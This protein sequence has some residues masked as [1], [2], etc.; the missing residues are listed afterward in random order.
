MVVE[1]TGVF[2]HSDKAS[3]HIDAGAKKVVISAPAKGDLKTVV[4]GKELIR[5]GGVSV[6]AP[7][8]L[9]DCQRAAF[10]T[11]ASAHRAGAKISKLLDHGYKVFLT[12]ADLTIEMSKTLAELYSRTGLRQISFDGLEGNRSTGLGTYGESLMPYTWY[13]ALAPELKDHMI[14]DA[15]R[16]NHFFWHIYSRMNWGCLLYTSPSPRD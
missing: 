11:L 12:E 9:L 7:W 8:R 15:S 2:T 10:G 4:L 14:I 5:Y 3:A 1:S 16:T 13:N 6:V